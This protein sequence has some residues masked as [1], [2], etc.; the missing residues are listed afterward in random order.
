M[1]CPQGGKQFMPYR[2]APYYVLFVLAVIVVGFWPSYFTQWTNVP[3][4]FHAHGIAATLWVTMVLV[5]SWTVHRGQLPLH[6][7]IG[8]TSLF[9][10]PFLMAGFA[11]IIDV[12]AKGYVA[13]DSPVRVMFGGSFLIGMALAMAAY[14]TFFY[15]ALKYRRKVWVHSGYML[16]TPLFLFESPFSRILNMVLPGFTVRGP[17]DFGRI[18]TSIEFSMGL[19]LFFILLVCWKFRNGAQPFMVA[20]G[21]IVAQM[22]TMLLLNDW[23]A[24]KPILF[25]IAQTPSSLVWLT[26]FA[27]GVLT[28]W[29][30]WTEGTRRARPAAPVLTG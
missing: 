6:R 16:A 8:K 18:M 2:N 5:Q 4:Q 21:F 27:I 10:F 25:L 22:I 15:R 23:A 9:L 17:E 20:A 11:G 29:A 13:N 30:G 1:H 3:W 12:T 26:G 14:V 7:A 19:E 28:A 24:L